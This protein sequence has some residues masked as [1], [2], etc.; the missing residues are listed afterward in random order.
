M[1]E[2][3]DTIETAATDGIQ[4]TTVDGRTTVA[5]PIPDLIAADKHIAGRTALTGTNDRG[6]SKSAWGGLRPARVIPPGTV[7][8]TGGTG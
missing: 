6:G 1:P 2:I 5:T 4:S 3:S 7:G 8:P